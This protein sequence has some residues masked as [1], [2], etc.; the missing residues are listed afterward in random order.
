MRPR[1]GASMTDRPT[2]RRSLKWLLSLGAGAAAGGAWLASAGG[3]APRVHPPRPEQAMS[4]PPR[5][6]PS[7]FLAH[8]APVLLDMPQW[9][10]ELRAWAEALPRPRAVLMV[11]AHWTGAP[12]TLG[13]TRTV[14]LV[15]DFHGFPRKYYQQQYPAPGAP[16]LARRVRE[17]LSPHQPVADEP[18]RGL[19]HGAYVPLVA[20]YPAA[21]VPVLQVSMPTLDP[22]ALFRLGQALAPLREEGVLLIGSGF[23]TH[24]LRTLDWSG[25]SPPPAWAVDFDAWTASALDRH[26]TGALLDYQRRGP[27]VRDALP[28]VEHFVPLLIS[29]GA[30]EGEPVSYPVTGFFG[31][32][33]TRRSVQFGSPPA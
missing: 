28:T 10:G 9:V 11:S 18:T 8:G 16:E 2:R 6:L 27:G 20:M 30:G 5:K 22:G 19:D 25:A 17:L 15:Y 29:L 4:P 7:L 33:F 23:I 3:P 14:P 31:G 13:A 32:S 21:D 1:L 12:V 24:N 26:D